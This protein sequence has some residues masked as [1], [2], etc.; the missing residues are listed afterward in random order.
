MLHHW[1]G[2][3]SGSSGGILPF[4]T[5][6]GHI[7]SWLW[8]KA[9]PKVA[10][11]IFMAV[12]LKFPPCHR[13][14]MPISP[15]KWGWP[16]SCL[17]FLSFYYFFF[18]WSLRLYAP[19]NLPSVE[20]PGLS[21]CRLTDTSG[22]SSGEMRPKLK[23]KEKEWVLFFQK[24]ICSKAIMPC[25]L[26]WTSFFIAVTFAWEWDEKQFFRQQIPTCSPCSFPT[27]K[28]WLL[29]HGPSRET[30]ADPAPCPSPANS[31][32]PN[33]CHKKKEK[34][35]K[36]KYSWSFSICSVIIFDLISCFLLI[37]FAVLA[38]QK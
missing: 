21:T 13:M 29:Q 3:C 34:E 31:S 6:Q 9:A 15:L 28:A 35:K 22:G 17:F 5:P 24:A 38:A 18:L 16:L 30:E 23:K 2:A 20:I 1:H 11:P 36:E 4:P 32:I 14:F 12:C 26:C 10:V 8:L 37:L 19:S 25:Y 33:T 7:E 27:R